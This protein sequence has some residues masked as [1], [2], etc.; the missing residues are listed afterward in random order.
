MRILGLVMTIVLVSG[1]ASTGASFRSGVGDRFLEH[2]PY[3]AGRAV[4]TMQ[5]TPRI[6]HFPIVFQRGAS[7]SEIFEPASGV[8]SAVAALLSDMNA[9]LDS[10]LAGPAL[11]A[12]S[13][14]A[15]V[16]PNVYFGCAY[17][18]SNDCV[19]RGDSVLGRNDALK[20][21]IGRP[22]AEWIAR[23]GPLLDSAGATHA[24]VL[25]LEVGQYWLKQ[26]GLRGAKSVELG[27]GY[28]V[29]QP[30]LTSL[31]TPVSVLQ[32]TAALMDRDGLAVRIGAE[33]ILAQRTALVASAIGGQR[34]IAPEDVA[35]ARTLRHT[36]RVGQPLVWRAGMCELVRQLA[37]KNC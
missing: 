24:L 8:G 12:I 10:M 23:L 7:Q 27:T 17:D 21:A 9:A 1:C 33:G 36:D 31:E 35:R 22:S 37:G 26:S 6:A 34:L 25:T 4:A 5:P 16:A 29:S 11:A 28:S 2:P 19:E 18:A 32:V 15:V 20:L 30:W 3:Y 13:G 14:S